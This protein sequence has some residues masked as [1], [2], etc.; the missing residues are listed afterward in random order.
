MNVQDFL[1]NYQGIHY[2]TIVSKNKLFSYQSFVSAMQQ[3]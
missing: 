2:V 3:L 1:C